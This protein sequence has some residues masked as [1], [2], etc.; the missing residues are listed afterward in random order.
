MAGTLWLG[1]ISICRPKSNMAAFR[2]ALL[3][4]AAKKFGQ[5]SCFL[6]PDPRLPGTHASATNVD[7][8]GALGTRGI[9][10]TALGSS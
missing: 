2:W 4:S 6:K 3:L 9:I 1:W 5:P 7:A 10:G 8:P